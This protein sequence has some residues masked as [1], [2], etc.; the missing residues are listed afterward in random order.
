MTLMLLSLNCDDVSIQSYPAT[1]GASESRKHSSRLLSWP[2]SKL[3]MSRYDVLGFY[4]TP[5]SWQLVH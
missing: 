3:M 1:G 2:G 4:V 5:P